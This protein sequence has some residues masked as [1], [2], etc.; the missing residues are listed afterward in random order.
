[1]DSIEHAYTIPDDALK[2]MAEKKIFMVPTDPELE[3]NDKRLMDVMHL[4]PERV[5]TMKQQ[6]TTAMKSRIDR[7]VKA[8]VQIAA[9]SD[10][11]YDNPT[12]GRGVASLTVLEAYA[13]YGMPPIDV[14][15]TAT[16]NAAALLGMNNIGAIQSGKFADMIAVDGDPLADIA[17]LRKV[18][19]V[20]KNGVVA[21]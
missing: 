10:M 13:R 7:A 6:Q 3:D 4:T 15:R 19:W 21:N 16:T 1:V 2:T 17:T 8:G 5:A 11:Y 20:M 12:W 9:G 14:I 18:R